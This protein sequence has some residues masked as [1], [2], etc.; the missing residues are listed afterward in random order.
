MPGVFTPVFA[1]HSKS[2]NLRGSDSEELRAAA[3][4]SG[5]VEED[6][7]DRRTRKIDL[8]QRVHASDFRQGTCCTI[9]A[10]YA[11]NGVIQRNSEAAKSNKTLEGWFVRIG[12]VE[13]A[14][15]SIQPLC[16]LSAFAF[17]RLACSSAFV[18]ALSVHSICHVQAH[19]G[20]TP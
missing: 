18:G 9:A 1:K 20:N 11:A 17:N 12:Q 5:A 15:R 7:G 10:R 3:A 8:V 4:S 14:N 16:H 13:L 6:P 2:L 19:A